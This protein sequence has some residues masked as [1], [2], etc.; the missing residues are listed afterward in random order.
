MCLTQDMMTH[1]GIVQILLDIILDCSRHGLSN[2]F[3]TEGRSVAFSPLECT[4]GK[5]WVF[6]LLDSLSVRAI[7]HF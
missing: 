6:G 2:T 5:L 7:P 4:Y 3:F 1:E